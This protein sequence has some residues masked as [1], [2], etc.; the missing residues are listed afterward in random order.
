MSG[1]GQSFLPSYFPPDPDCYAD[2]DSLKAGDK[3]ECKK[4]EKNTGYAP[5]IFNE[6]IYTHLDIDSEEIPGT[7]KRHEMEQNLYALYYKTEKLREQ[8][9]EEIIKNF[10]DDLNL[11]PEGAELS[12]DKTKYNK[13]LD[14]LCKQGK[15]LI[16]QVY[17]IERNWYETLFKELKNQLTEIGP[18]LTS[19]YRFLHNLHWV[20]LYV[21]QY[22]EGQSHEEIK[23][24]F[25]E[26]VKNIIG[27]LE[28]KKG[29]YKKELLDIE[30]ELNR[31]KEKLI[32]FELSTEI[33][34]EVSD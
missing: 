25:E 11:F 30:S 20:S 29:E 16:K 3:K 8:Y 32:N 15:E 12:L 18:F 17:I 33:Y 14:N 28:I 10:K 26:N 34:P 31:L 22:N 13:E 1:W 2:L 9:N 23:N 21:P 7:K 4:I 24:N 27:N 6:F 19:D 5:L